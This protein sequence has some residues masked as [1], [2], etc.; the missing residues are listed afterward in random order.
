MSS[1]IVG[2]NDERGRRVYTGWLR[3]LAG[4]GRVL[5]A[6]FYS[7]DRVPRHDG[8]CVKVAFPA[9]ITPSASSD[10]RS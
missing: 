9:A 7:T 5:Y 3:R 8:P 1:H 6:G 4:S 2:M 10:S